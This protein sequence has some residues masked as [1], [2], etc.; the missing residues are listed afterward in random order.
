MNRSGIDKLPSLAKLLLTPEDILGTV[1]VKYEPIQSKNVITVQNTKQ[2]PKL[3]ITQYGPEILTLLKNNLVI[4][5]D[6]PTGTGK[7]RY[8]PY[9][10]A[11]TLDVRV[12]VAIPTTV[13]VRDAYNFVG[14]YS[15][16]SLGYAAAR[17]VKYQTQTQLVYATTGHITA[18][19]INIFRRFS[20]QVSNQLKRQVLDVLGDV[21]FIDEVHTGIMEITLLIGLINYIW[22][23]EKDVY[24]GPKV[25]FSSAT[26]NRGDVF[27]FFPDFPIFKVDVNRYPVEVKYLPDSF[28]P[29]QINI[30]QKIIEII[31]NELDIWVGSKVKYHII[32]FR[33][34][35]VEVD[36][37]IN[38]L[39]KEFK[40]DQPIDFYPAYSQLAPT[41]LD[42]IFDVSSNMKVVVGTNI[43][44]SSVTIPNVGVV[45]DD[46]LVKTSETSSSGGYRLA[47][48]YISRAE[49]DQRKGRTGRTIP[50]K[51]YRLCSLSFYDN[52]PE[53]RVREIDRIPIY[54]VVLQLLDVNLKP[55]V[56]LK[57]FPAKYYQTVKILTDFGT[58]TDMKVTEVGR[59][60]SKIPLSIQNA[61]MVYLACQELKDL[62]DKNQQLYLRNIIAVASMLENY[63]SGYFYIPRRGR[64]ESQAEYQLR[65]DVQTDKYH[66]KFRGPT[67]IHTLVNIFWSLI[68]FTRLAR[69]YDWR[70]RNRM[71]DYVKNFAE[72]NQMNNRKLHELMVVLR[73]VENIILDIL[74]VSIDFGQLHPDGA[75]LQLGNQAARVFAKA[76]VSNLLIRDTDR[77]GKIIYV[78]KDGIP[79]RIT[80]RS[81]FSYIQI[82]KTSGPI[83][84]V[85]GQ[86]IEVQTTG[87]RMNLASVL[88]DDQ[89]IEQEPKEE[90][91]LLSESA[92]SEVA[93]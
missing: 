47:L 88:V 51:D 82:T 13:A 35:V 50:G 33:P 3:P 70:T 59:F 57:I 2:F 5:I 36:N 78:N 68:D 92:W 29:N 48:G 74:N 17:Q 61:Y 64:N 85:A 58:L 9:L 86:T 93:E 4:G 41:D 18:K 80:G 44:E 20:G 11:K 89:F 87:N 63:D 66:E 30:D 83:R 24:S 71:Y 60:V 77:K 37:T 8:L 31:R 23:D 49:A 26:F 81:T 14:K 54:N 7:T 73:D 40:T 12:R 19:L 34:G 43:I 27:D 91:E 52:L 90:L 25:V 46:M 65:R 72:E 22:R 15:D 28:D 69:S 21:V 1:K 84:L 62:S 79:Y 16:I 32:V 42:R 55:D 6:S 10:I 53:H 56:V 38:A 76:Y 67:D 45:I 75:Y 39:F